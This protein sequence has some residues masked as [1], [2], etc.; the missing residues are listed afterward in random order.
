MLPIL[1]NF[2]SVARRFK[3]AMTL[4]ILGLSVAFA[5]F[6]VIMVQLDYDYGFDKFHKDYDKI[7]RLEEESGGDVIV[8]RAFAERFFESPYIVTGGLIFTSEGTLSFYV[9]NEEGKRNNY[10]EKILMVTPGYLDVFSFDFVEGAKDALLAPGSVVIPLS[11]AR[12]IFRYEPAVGKQIIQ[13]SGASSTVLAVYRDFPAN[14]ILKNNIY[15]A[16]PPDMDKDSWDNCNYI[17][18]L[19]VNQASNVHLLWDNFKRNFDF[20]AVFGENQHWIRETDFRLTALP[21]VHF[22]NDLQYDETPKANRQTL[23]ILFAIAIVIIVIAVINFTNFSMALTPMRV[24]SINTQRVFGAPLGMIRLSLVFEAVFFC[25]LSYLAALLLVSVFQT[26][27]LASV[28]DGNL[29]LTAQPLIIFVTAL[30]ALVI[31]LIAGVYPAYFMTSFEPQLVLKGSF[32]LNPKGKII[33]NTMIGIQYIASFA[34][35][36]GATFMYLQNN[37]MQ[38]S[39]LGYDKDEIVTANVASIQR[40]SRDAFINKLKTHSSIEDITFGRMLLSIMD[41]YG[42]YGKPYKDSEISFWLFEVDYNFLK[43]MGIELTDG[44]DFRR[45]DKRVFVFNETARKQYNLELNATIGTGEEFAEGAI[46]GF[47]PDVKYT[48]FRVMVDPMAFYMWDGARVF[49]N[50]FIKIKKGA[51]KR[52]AMAHI[53]ATLAEFNP[54]ITFDVRFYDEVLQKLYEKEKALNTLISLFSLL[55]IFISI[56]GV[57]GLVMFDSECRRKEIGI[58]KV[59]GATTA[60]IL[61]MFNKIYFRLLAVCFVIAAPLAWYTVNRWL[62]NFAYK[63]PMHWWVFLCAFVSIVVITVCTVTFQSLNVANEDPVKSIKRTCQ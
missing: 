50:A 32:G 52:A 46:I 16:L 26:T 9:D 29:T 37:F 42:T 61:L 33:R 15:S 23:M 30:I 2:L 62:E 54:S 55:A 11:M 22:V 39:P 35:L 53:K 18:Y 4:N 31:G 56:I 51:N 12:K 45:E 19:R 47:V 13:N 59:C 38:N 14:S 3:L 5:A 8:S 27:P 28:V 36:I 60:E 21:D 49:D 57:F 24:H 40:E 25:F 17:A 6:M 34:L 63:T 10:Q 44:R 1:R 20:K 48:S 58:R 7:F 43:V 41:K